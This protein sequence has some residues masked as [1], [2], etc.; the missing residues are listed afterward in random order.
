LVSLDEPS[1]LNLTP[2]LAGTTACPT[3]A[4]TIRD[5]DATEELDMV[6]VVQ[7]PSSRD[8]RSLSLD[9]TNFSDHIKMA[10]DGVHSNASSETVC[11]P[12]SYT[13]AAPQCDI[14]GW[15]AELK[16]K[17]EAGCCSPCD[18]AGVPAGQK[19][20]LLQR[21]FSF[22]EGKSQAK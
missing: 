10:L 19:R 6:G 22:G 14:Y 2:S 7:T 15:E 8:Y 3:P 18:G 12:E 21:V 17:L 5:G 13:R 9:L 1:P 20:N 11:D 16:R 4:I